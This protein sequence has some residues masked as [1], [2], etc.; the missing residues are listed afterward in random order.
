MSD[1]KDIIV[2]V[3]GF[4]ISFYGGYIENQLLIVTGILLIILSLIF[5][6][7]FYENETKALKEDIRILNAQINTQIE[8]K[9]FGEI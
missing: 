2:Q 5:Q 3:F 6:L 8:L 9:K 4:C 1:L 7:Q